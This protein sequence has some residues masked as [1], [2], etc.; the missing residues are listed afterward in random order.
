MFRRVCV[1]I[2]VAAFASIVI[3]A[4]KSEKPVQRSIY[5]ATV[6]Q[7]GGPAL[8]L[9]ADDF[10][11]V[12]GGVK[13]K[14][15]KAA[16]AASPMRV[17]LLVDNSKAVEPALAG[18][19]KG[20][21]AFVDALPAEDELAYVTIGRSSRTRVKP[22]TDRTKIKAEV[23]KVSADGEPTVLLDGLRDAFNQ[24][25]KQPEV[26][27]PVFV[28]VAAET[29]DGSTAV[30]G[31]D[32]GKLVNEM[33]LKGASVHVVGIQIPKPGSIAEYAKNLT[34]NLGGLYESTAPTGV[35]AALTK[36]TARL[37]EDHTRMSRTYQVEFQGDPTPK[38]ISIK[39]LKPDVGITKVSA[40]R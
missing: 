8:D 28:V 2:A 4:Q 19:K 12:E 25:M 6:D 29:A 7:A 21:P 17:A 3:S 31:D 16:I 5:V 22:M 36:M 39:I 35:E 34:Q 37:N 24:F 40:T 9:K 33:L 14:V 27:W 11:I 1:L 26:K 23:S 20:L 15:D 13:K 32:Y 30:R 18:L 38:E 10:E